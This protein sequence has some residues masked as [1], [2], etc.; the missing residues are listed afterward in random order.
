MKW[1]AGFLGKKNIK[2]DKTAAK[3]V[4]RGELIALN[5]FIKKLERSQLND[6]TSHREELDKQEQTNPKANR[7]K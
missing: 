3:A 7:R 4:L 5:T 2:I 6:L 1:K